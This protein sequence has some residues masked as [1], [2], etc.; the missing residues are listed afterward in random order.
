M[1]NS[2]YFYKQSTDSISEIQTIKNI[3]RE[4]TKASGRGLFEI[5]GEFKN[6]EID[7]D[8]F[9]EYFKHLGF[10]VLLLGYDQYTYEWNYKISWFKH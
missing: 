5:K 2:E 1:Q 4:I 8:S 9:V 6:N 3:N 10:K 7:T